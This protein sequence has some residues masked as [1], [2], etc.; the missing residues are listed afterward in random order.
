MWPPAIVSGELGAFRDRAIGE[1]GALPRLVRG[2]P[3]VLAHCDRYSAPRPDD[4]ELGAVGRSAGEVGAVCVSRDPGNLARIETRSVR[5]GRF[6]MGLVAKT[7]VRMLDWANFLDALSAGELSADSAR[8]RGTR[9][10]SCWHGPGMAPLPGKSTR[11]TASRG[12][13]RAC[14]RSRG[15]WRAWRM[16]HTGELGALCVSD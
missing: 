6:S 16:A 12:T 10:G 8:G 9:R 2:I 7:A 3:R 1:L 11:F 15:I 5:F 14:R 13:W 4:G